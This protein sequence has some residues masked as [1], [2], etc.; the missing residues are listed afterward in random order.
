[1]L[2]H[3]FAGLRDSGTVTGDRWHWPPGSRRLARVARDT[4]S[5]VQTAMRVLV[6]L[7]IPAVV[8]GWLPAAVQATFVPECSEGRLQLLGS[9]SVSTSCLPPTLAVF[10]FGCGI[11][12]IAAAVGF[13]M[14]GLD[15]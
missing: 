14:R 3:N 12:A 10:V 2:F 13:S 8:F 7:A 11:A 6:L 5:G 15:R 9:L 4:F 1:M